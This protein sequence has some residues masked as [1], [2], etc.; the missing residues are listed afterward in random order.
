L[1]LETKCQELES[2]LNQISFK[3]NINKNTDD[4]NILPRIPHKLEFAG[5]RSSVTSIKFHP[6][7]SL[8]ASSS[9]DFSI[10]IWDWDSNTL[11][12]TLKGHT[13][14]VQCLSWDSK[15]NLLGMSI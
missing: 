11:E 6:L 4:S 5:H 9:E 1:E 14:S 13:K 12:K 7:Y 2:E 15:G 10:K 3:P 8:L